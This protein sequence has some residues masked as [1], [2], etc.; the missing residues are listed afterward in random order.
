[1]LPVRS[2]RERLVRFV[3]FFALVLLLCDVPETYVLE[4]YAKSRAELLAA[5]KDGRIGPG[6][7]MF[8]AEHLVGSNKTDLQIGVFDFLRRKYSTSSVHDAAEQ[9]LSEHG[10]T[11]EERHAIRSNLLVPLL[12]CNDNGKNEHSQN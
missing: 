4:D 2:S 10:L 12:S 9:Y 3:P 6:H 7:P 1:M 11:C 5:T 8:L